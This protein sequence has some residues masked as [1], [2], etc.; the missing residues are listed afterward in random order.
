MAWATIVFYR[1]RAFAL[2]IAL[3]LYV[4]A[5]SIITGWHYAIDGIAGAAVALVT[6]AICRTAYV[7]FHKSVEMS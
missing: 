7:Y 1:T 3:A 6:F 5:G 2:A 4:F